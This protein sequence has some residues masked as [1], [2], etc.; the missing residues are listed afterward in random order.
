MG[1]R[2]AGMDQPHQRGL[3][4]GHCCRTDR[5]QVTPHSGVA[6]QLAAQEAK[7]WARIGDRRQTEVA[8]DRGRRLLDS[9][10]Y[11]ENL[12]HHFVVDPGKFDFYAMDCYRL[13]ADDQM[14]EHLANEV[15]QAS[16]DF[17]GKE[18]APMRLAEARVTL[19][20]VAARGGDVNSA[21][22]Q[23]ERALSGERSRCRSLL[24]TSRELSQALTKRYPSAA[25]TR[26]YLDHL[27]V[28]R[29]SLNLTPPPVEQQRSARAPRPGRVRAGSEWRCENF[30]YG[31]KAARRAA[32]AADSARSPLLPLA[33]P[34]RR[35]K[36][37]VGWREKT[38]HR[39]GPR[40]HRRRP[41][42][43]RI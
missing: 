26:E 10:P 3:P 34:Q 20:V 8:L 13:L 9:M 41:G 1:A 33:L 15:I 4:R 27:R 16:T 5:T 2:D 37:P 19:G 23:S 40:F 21:V 32:R 36:T 22:E 38:A 11:P 43:R 6:V 25:S 35:R 17:D 42:P 24:M 14:T 18:R 28:L 7:A 39:R 12:D 30:L 29:Q 31:F